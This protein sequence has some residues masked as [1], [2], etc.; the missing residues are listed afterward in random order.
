MEDVIIKSAVFLSLVIFVFWCRAK[1]EQF[2][3][4]NLL[5]KYGKFL[6]DRRSNR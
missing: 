6:D 5:K 1:K 2:K 4:E 3:Y